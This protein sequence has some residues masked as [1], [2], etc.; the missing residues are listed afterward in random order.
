MR[1]PWQSSHG[2]H[3]V[4]SQIVGGKGLSV[5]NV[6]GKLLGEHRGKQ[7]EAQ[8]AVTSP[9]SDALQ[10]T[11]PDGAGAVTQKVKDTIKDIVG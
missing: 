2:L 8:K 7:D 3:L 4:E 6:N 10:F 11:A 1:G 9:G 5:G